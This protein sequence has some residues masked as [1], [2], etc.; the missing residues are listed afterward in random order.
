MFLRIF[1][2]NI[3]PL[4]INRILYLDADLIANKDLSELYYQNLD[5]RSVA[6][7]RDVNYD[8]DELLK[9]AADLEIN[10]DYFNSGV[11]LFNLPLMRECTLNDYY[12]FFVEHK[13]VIIWPD[14]DILNGI[15][16][17]QIKVLGN[18]I[19]NVQISNWRFKGELDLNQV[20][21]IH[22]IGN[23]KPWFKTY[24]NPAAKIWDKYYAI[25]FK[26]GKSYLISKKIHRK[27]EKIILIPLNNFIINF[28]QKSYFF[29][30][31]K[32]LFKK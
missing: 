28:Y 1:A 13:D 14:Q 21:I 30:K 5:D 9:H 7:V 4:D 29:K 27:L 31:T 3:L 10:H 16:S 23:S 20:A 24:T 8:S 22:Y 12:E 25:T 26:K 18:N 6:V 11:I 19:Y 2:F 32:N 17:N 15:F